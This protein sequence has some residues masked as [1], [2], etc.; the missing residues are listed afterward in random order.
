MRHDNQSETI[1]VF[2]NDNE[3]L[4]TQHVKP[5]VRPYIHPI[6][7]PDGNGILTEFSPVHHKHQTGL[8]WG[9]KKVNG[10]DYFMNW[11][12]DY[13]RRVSATVIDQRGTIVK[14]QTVYDLLNENGNA[15]LTETQTWSM[16]QVDGKF[17]LDLEWSGEAKKDVTMEKFYVGG[18]FLRMP[19]R[20]G[21]AGGVINSEGKRNSDAEGQRARWTDIGIQIDGREDKAH[22]AIFEHP[23]NAG[24]PNAWRVD[25]ELGVGPS[26]QILGDW[27]IQNGKSEGIRY[28]LIIYTGEF[29]NGAITRLWKEYTS[30][31]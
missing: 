1:A 9:L 13:W 28:R 12:E 25:N 6:V 2:R 29:D 4:L 10:R 11:G 31:K 18:L 26:R 14:W 27:S 17:L 8:Y 3:L 30:D 16:Q 5:T 19:W 15:V 22:V 21:V 23:A 7:A 20:E 24:F